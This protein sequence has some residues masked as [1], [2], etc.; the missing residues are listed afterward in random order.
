MPWHTL[1]KL[2]KGYLWYLQKKEE[3]RKKTSFIM[4]IAVW[5]SMVAKI[6]AAVCCFF[7]L[8]TVRCFSENDEHL[9][10]CLRLVSHP[11][12]AT[13]PF[14][15]IC[16]KMLLHPEKDSVPVN[17]M[18]WFWNC[19][20]FSLFFFL[21]GLRNQACHQLK[22]ILSL[23]SEESNIFQHYYFW[24]RKVHDIRCRGEHPIHSW[25]WLLWLRW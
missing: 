13:F 6:L 25:V 8:I 14:V 16:I 23:S 19:K 7:I 22:Q 24:L 20:L 12:A 17:T 5:I 1:S 11:A 15:F 10:S 2:Y 21:E 3:E 4:G 18:Q 9:W